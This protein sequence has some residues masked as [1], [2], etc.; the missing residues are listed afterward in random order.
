MSEPKCAPKCQSWPICGHD[1]TPFHD[2]EKCHMRPGSMTASAAGCICPVLDNEHGHA[3]PR[4]GTVVRI[5]CPV[6]SQIMA[7]GGPGA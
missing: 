3:D 4:N 5:G 6:H 2:C 1:E 7:G